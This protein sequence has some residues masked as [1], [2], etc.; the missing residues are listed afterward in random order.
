MPDLE[1]SGMGSHAS[2][3]SEAEQVTED[4]RRTVPEQVQIA[5]L[6]LIERCKE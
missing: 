4:L 5:I 1:N 6:E 3:S 2:P